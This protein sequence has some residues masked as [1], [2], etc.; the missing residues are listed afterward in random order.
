M[1]RNWGK[2]KVTGKNHIFQSI[3]WET[4]WFSLGIFH[5][6]SVEWALCATPRGV[7]LEVPNEHVDMA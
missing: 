3:S 7:V 4:P 1:I 2:K 5:R 6:L